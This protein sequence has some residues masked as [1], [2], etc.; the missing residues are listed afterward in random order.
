MCDSSNGFKLCTCDDEVKEYDWI[1]DWQDKRREP[2]HRRGRAAIPE[3]SK[4]D[5]ELQRLIIKSLN[6]GD[7]FDFEYEAEA[8]DVLSMK[9]QNRNFRFRFSGKEWEVDKSTSLTGWRSQMILSKKGK[10]ERIGD[11]PPK[12]NN[13]KQLLRDLI[14][15]KD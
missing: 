10:L 6:Q 1:L 7:C 5:E 11:F 9:L 2:R 12:K 8:G 14:K 3:F 15:G 13:R 4:Q